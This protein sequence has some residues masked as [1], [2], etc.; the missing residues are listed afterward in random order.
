M[1]DRGGARQSRSRRPGRNRHF[2]RGFEMET[3]ILLGIGFG[4]GL[5][6]A[7]WGI[8]QLR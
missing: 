4:A 6:I 3:Y 2:I 8:I 7:I 1:P 5:L